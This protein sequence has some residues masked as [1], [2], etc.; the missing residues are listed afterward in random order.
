MG[1]SNLWPYIPEVM[2]GSLLL[3][4]VIVIVVDGLKK[5]ESDD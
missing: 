5:G 2:F 4:V 1:G 3:I